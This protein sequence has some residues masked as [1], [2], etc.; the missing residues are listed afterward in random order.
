MMH[1][2]CATRLI[3]A[4]MSPAYDLH[5]ICAPM[6]KAMIQ[7]TL[8]SSAP[9]A[10]PADV[11]PSAADW[12]PR[13]D[14]PA[15]PLGVRI[16]ARTR[17]HQTATENLAARLLG[18][19]RHVRAAAMLRE[20]QEEPRGLGRAALDRRG[21]LLGS[22]AFWPIHIG[23]HPG[24]LLGPLLVDPAHEG[25][26]IG[27]HLVQAGVGGLPPPHLVL[28]VGDVAYYEPLG[29]RALGFQALKLDLPAPVDKAR[30]LVCAPP[31]FALAELEGRVRAGPH[32][33]GA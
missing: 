29:F 17:S 11:S 28:L 14:L 24:W 23:A 9:S 22:V 31:D 12:P 8:P 16:V 32:Q 21:R 18:P 7:K 10:P 30:L 3:S 27:G 5:M 25:R 33:D 6:N 15:L 4:F 1:F 2:G 26:G 20:G 13:L 19:G